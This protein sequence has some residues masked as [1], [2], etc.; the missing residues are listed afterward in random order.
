MGDQNAQVNDFFSKFDNE[1]EN[2]VDFS[3]SLPEE[4]EV[5]AKESEVKAN[6]KGTKE[7]TSQ[8]VDSDSK[9]KDDK[10][11]PFHEHPRWKEKLASEKKLKAANKDM[12]DKFEKMQQ[13]IEALENKPKTD[14]EI[15]NMTPKEAAKYAREQAEKEFNQKSELSKKEDD[16]ADRYIDEQLEAIKDT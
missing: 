11:T 5:E 13:K 15:D 2:L 6:P 8:E 12:N 16:E 10:L 9:D 7:E 3:D 4:K 14:D 1:E